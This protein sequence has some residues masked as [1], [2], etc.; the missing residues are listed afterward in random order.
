MTLVFC[1][2]YQQGESIV[3]GSTTGICVATLE[4]YSQHSRDKRRCCQLFRGLTITK[5]GYKLRAGGRVSY[6]RV[7]E[8]LLEK[9]MEVGLDAK[10]FGLHSLRSGGASTVGMK[11]H[12]S[13][14][15]IL[16]IHRPIPNYTI[17]DKC[18]VLFYG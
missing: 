16:V 17:Q 6:T 5:V 8:L 7:H 14:F 9:L 2:H 15:L 3:G 13:A 10:P 11:S 1:P 4:H 12:Y 18:G